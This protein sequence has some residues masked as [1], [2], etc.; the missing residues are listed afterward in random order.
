MP[1]LKIL[2][3]TTKILRAATKTRCSQINKYILKKRKE[4]KKKK[5]GSQ[6]PHT[7]QL[8]KDLAAPS[9]Q[10]ASFDSLNCAQ[11][12]LVTPCFCQFHEFPKCIPP[13]S[14]YMWSSLCL[15][16]SPYFLF[17]FISHLNY[18]FLSEIFPTQSIP[19]CPPFSLSLVFVFDFLQSMFH[20]LICLLAY[21][22]TPQSPPS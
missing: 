1:Q 20:W 19:S 21:Y 9:L 12:A 22:L 10:I 3:T 13:Q 7:G 8:L 5:K 16:C 11:W 2:H 18:H 4:K 15:E 6:S 14:F 17:S